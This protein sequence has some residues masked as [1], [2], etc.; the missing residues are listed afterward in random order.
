MV[1][2]AGV[3]TDYWCS[4]SSAGVLRHVG[5]ET[6]QRAFITQKKTLNRRLRIGRFVTMCVNTT[7]GAPQINEVFL[8]QTDLDVIICALDVGNVA[9]QARD[10]AYFL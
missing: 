5:A 4:P 9:W 8:L 1:V 3:P 2:V 7:D 10:V 6:V